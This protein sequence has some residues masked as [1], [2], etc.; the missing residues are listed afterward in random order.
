MLSRGDDYPLHQTPE[1]IAFAGSDR[2]FSDDI[3]STAITRWIGFFALAFGVYPH[4]DIADA[5]FCVVRDGVQHC[6]HA[7]LSWAA[8]G[9]TCASDRSRSRCSSRCAAA[10]D[11]RRVQGRRRA[12]RLYRPRISARGAALQR[13]IGH[14][15]SWTTPGD[16]ERALRGLGRGRRQARGAPAPL[17]RHARPQLGSAPVGAPDAQRA[18]GRAA[19]GILLAVDAD[20]LRA[21][22]P[23]FH[24]NADAEGP[25]GTCARRWCPTGGHR[26]TVRA[27]PRRGWRRGWS[28]GRAGRVRPS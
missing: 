14:A 6:L 23:F 21:P 9:W 10:R 2:N 11:R 4:L 8:S 22:K 5:H 13:R 17:R 20:E 7:S 24:I 25:R 28:R 27:L 16:A 3:S 12:V 26:R 15:R 19:D 18:Y 1:P